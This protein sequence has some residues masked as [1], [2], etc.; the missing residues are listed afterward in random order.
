[1]KYRLPTRQQSFDLR[2]L[3]HGHC[4]LR[5]RPSPTAQLYSRRFDPTRPTHGTRLYQATR[6]IGQRLRPPALTPSCNPVRVSLSCLSGARQL[7]GKGLA[8]RDEKLPAARGSLACGVVEVHRG[9]EP[10]SPLPERDR[11]LRFLSR[12]SFVLG[13]QAGT[14]SLASST[15]RRK[16]GDR[17][18]HAIRYP[19]ARRWLIERITTRTATKL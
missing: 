3:P 1:M 8:Q 11:L 15:L 6:I 12:C 10:W 2:P 14:G 7:A 16:P 18:T 9:V 5:S 4:L 17:P 13:P 19:L